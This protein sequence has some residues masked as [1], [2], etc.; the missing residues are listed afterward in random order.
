MATKVK[1][2]ALTISKRLE[3]LFAES[4]HIAIQNKPPKQENNTTF[5]AHKTEN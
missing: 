2:A 1:L 4:N 5:I 3:A